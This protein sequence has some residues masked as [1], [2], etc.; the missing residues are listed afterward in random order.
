MRFFD[1]L[2]L[3]E[4]Y[5]SVNEAKDQFEM[6]FHEYHRYAKFNAEFFSVID[7]SSPFVSIYN[8][9]VGIQ[10]YTES[11]KTTNFMW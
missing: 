10:P 11:R 3:Q 9:Y 2:Q 8:G 7:A 1:K 4:T 6:I 5:L